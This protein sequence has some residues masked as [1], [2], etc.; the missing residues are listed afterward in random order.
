M[1]DPTSIFNPNTFWGELSLC[2][3]SSFLMK[4]KPNENGL[5]TRTKI[6][7]FTS[8]FFSKWDQIR[9]FLFD[10]TDFFSKCDQIGSFL[11]IWSYLLKKYSM[12]N[13]IFGAVNDLNFLT[14]LINILISCFVKLYW[15]FTMAYS[16]PCQ[17][18]KIQHFMKIVYLLNYFYQRINLRCLTGL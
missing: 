15:S 8:N 4:L 3:S 6:F 12:E 1:N 9:S 18:S 13:F 7:F 14:F 16:E 11:R 2:L 5:S 10:I 17:T